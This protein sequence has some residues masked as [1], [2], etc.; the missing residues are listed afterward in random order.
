MRD[1]FDTRALEIHSGK[2]WEEDFVLRALDVIERYEMNAL[3]FHDPDIVHTIT[4][5][6]RYFGQHATWADAPP[7]R[8]EN[9]IYNKRKYISNIV[10]LCERRGVAFYLNVK[11]ITFPD[12]IVEVYPDLLVNGIVCPSHPKWIDFLEAKY[13]ELLS[14][15][16]G[17]AGIIVSVGSPE[18]RASMAARKCR[19]ERC[20][21]TGLSQ[22]YRDITHP[23]ATMAKRHDRRL[24][25]REFSYN[26]DEQKAVLDGLAPLSSEVELMVKV[27]PHDFYPTFPDNG[28]LD[29][30]PDREKWIEYDVHGQYFGWG[31]FPCPVVEDI[32]K[33]FTVA[34]EK[35]VRGVILRTDWERVNDLNCLDTLNIV[36]LAVGAMIARNADQDPG[37]ALKAALLREGFIRTSTYT[38]ERLENLVTVLLKLWPIFSKALYVRGF[39]LNSS[40]MF[41]SG[42]EHAWWTMLTKHSLDVWEPEA[43]ARVDFSVGD[44]VEEALE[45]KD[46][47]L[48]EVRELVRQL[49]ELSGQLLDMPEVD[50]IENVHILLG[51]YIEGFV[52][53]GKVAILARAV[54]EGEGAALESYKLRLSEALLALQQY[55]EWLESWTFER[56]YAHHVYMLMDYERV[57]VVIKDAQQLLKVGPEG[58]G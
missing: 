47:A 46:G 20:K 9:A 34:R 11:E 22:W 25:I 2:M 45:E 31:L 17:I 3:V 33:R 38:A 19:C 52:H 37:E 51:R 16:P 6:R 44:R 42:V 28:A 43:R 54:Q 39:V 15:F 40:S 49:G 35:G 26:P 56:R 21:A 13:D 14:D 12:E 24:I 50:R 58:I 27:Y 18:G 53:C 48:E 29:A 1:G 4:F 10:H 55:Q 7:R 5:P 32:E 23:L 8:G 30:L 36:N 41:P 57:A